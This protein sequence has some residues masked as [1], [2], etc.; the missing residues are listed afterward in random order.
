M[1]KTIIGIVVFK[2][3]SRWIEQNSPGKL[4]YIFLG[5]LVLA[6]IVILWYLWKFIK[7]KLVEKGYLSKN[8]LLTEIKDVK[9]EYIVTKSKLNID[10]NYKYSRICSVVIIITTIIS[11]FLCVDANNYL[12]SL[13]LPN[14]SWWF[15][16][17]IVETA[18]VFSYPIPLIVAFILMRSKYGFL[19]VLGAFFAGIAFG[20]VV[21]IALIFAAVLYPYR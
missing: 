5:L 7:T 8:L 13:A 14:I 12:K 17:A 19:Q 21:R 9:H 11:F 4:Y 2:R 15:L 18:I 16:K 10:L 1:W 3:I 20:V 6:I